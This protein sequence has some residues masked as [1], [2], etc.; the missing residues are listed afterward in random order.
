MLNERR[1]E[2]LAALVNEYV[3]SAHPVSSRT[4][5]ERYGLAC[6]PATVRN[7]LAALEDEGLVFQ[8]HISAGR[9]PT[10]AGY[11]TYLNGLA[12]PRAGMREGEVLDV[13]RRLAASERELDDLLRGAA[14]VLAGLTPYASV[15]VGPAPRMVRLRPVTL[16]P[17]SERDVLVVVVTDGGRVAKRLLQLRDPVGTEDLRDVEAFIAAAVTDRFAAEIEAVRHELLRDPTPF[18]RLVDTMLDVASGCLED[19]DGERVA[20][21]GLGRLLALPEFADASAAE[22]L[23]SL[24]EDT[25]DALAFLTRLAEPGETVV[26]I[27]HEN[28]DA[29]LT[30]VS[31]VATA[32]G[33]EGGS[34]VVCLNGPTRMEYLRA[35]AMT[36]CVADGLSESL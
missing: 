6:S 28:G 5:V 29:G 7:E 1:R 13:R 16:V 27:G 12:G 10:D 31:I 35:I 9:I 24:F 4:L 17:M 34:G 25:G 22:P 3:S 21:V 33:V 11:R 36:S 20:H 8:P 19:P 18:R 15:V 26:R 23:V 14:A 2:I 30:A 32:Y